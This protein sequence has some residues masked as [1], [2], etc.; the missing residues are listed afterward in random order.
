MVV[1]DH[2]IDRADDGGGCGQ[3]V[4]AVAHVLDQETLNVI[5]SA[6][7]I[8]VLAILLKW[9]IARLIAPLQQL[10]DPGLNKELKSKGRMVFLT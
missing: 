7:L 8:D 2:L 3:R 1:L 9:D 4:A 10:Q 5:N 6:V